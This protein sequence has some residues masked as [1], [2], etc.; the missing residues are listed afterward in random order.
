VWICAQVVNCVFPPTISYHP[1]SR[2]CKLIQ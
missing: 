2:K 1:H